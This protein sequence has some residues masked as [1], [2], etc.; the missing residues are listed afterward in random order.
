LNSTIH[1]YEEGTKVDDTKPI[2]ETVEPEINIDD[3]NTKPIDDIKSY[4]VDKTEFSSL[5][6]FMQNTYSNWADGSIAVFKQ[7]R[8]LRLH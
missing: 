3:I 4:I 7:M 5:D 6:E 1:T 2:I 8:Q